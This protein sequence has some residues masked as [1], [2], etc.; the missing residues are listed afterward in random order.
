MHLCRVSVCREESPPPYYP[1]TTTNPNSHFLAAIVDGYFNT[2]SS[3]A[4][5]PSPSF[6]L[7]VI[8]TTPPRAITT[9]ISPQE[10]KIPKKIT[11]KSLTIEVNKPSKSV[12]PQKKPA[13]R[14][15]KLSKSK[16]ISAKTILLVSPVKKQNPA[17][18]IS[19]NTNKD[20]AKKSAAKKGS[21]SPPVLLHKLFS[22]NSPS[23]LTR[24]P[25]KM[26]YQEILHNLKAA[27]DLDTPPPPTI[28]SELSTTT[29]FSAPFEHSHSV[30][31]DHFALLSKEHVPI[32]FCFRVTSLPLSLPLHHYSMCVCGK[33]VLKEHS[34]ANMLASDSN[35]DDDAAAVQKSLRLSLPRSLLSCQNGDEC[36]VSPMVICPQCRCLYHF[37]CSDV[38]LCQTCLVHQ[39]N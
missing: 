15:K 8:A 24:L 38:L 20:I 19:P 21:S 3:N 14:L 39:Q 26:S 37:N 22:T 11:L 30:F 35:I 23:S 16:P 28:S 36:D 34:Y 5:S 4:R 27:S 12:T 13:K 10:K 25:A 1:Y 6:P 33:A 17:A 29:S 31:H 9:S 7:S 2:K 18:S 32:D